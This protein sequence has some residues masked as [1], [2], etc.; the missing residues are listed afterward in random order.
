MAYHSFHQ[1][2]KSIMLF[3]CYVYVH[4][5]VYV[6]VCVCIYIFFSKAVASLSWALLGMIWRY[7]EA[8]ESHVGEVLG[9]HTGWATP[10]HPFGC[11]R[12][13]ATADVTLLPVWTFGVAWESSVLLRWNLQV[14]YQ[15]TICSLTHRSVSTVSSYL[16]SF[17]IFSSE[18]RIHIV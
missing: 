1:S 6:C 3:W 12:T 15:E 11:S 7:M 4:V 16:L 5:R 2:Q 10:L 14:R 17:C 8:T 9:S 13:D 18:M